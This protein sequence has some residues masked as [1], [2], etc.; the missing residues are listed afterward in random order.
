MMTWWSLP[1][2]LQGLLLAI[3][4]IIF[5]R[6]RGLGWWERLGHPLDTLSVAATQGYLLLYPLGPSGDATQNSDRLMIYLGICTFSCLLV[7]KD[8]WI[9]SKECPPTENWLHSLLFILHPIT[10]GVSGWL[11]YSQTHLELI[12]L[13]FGSLIFTAAAQLIYWGLIHDRQ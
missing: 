10:L 4:E 2:V 7:T 3:D 13:I 6:R 5:H 12:P 8:E 9:H 1:F 11:S